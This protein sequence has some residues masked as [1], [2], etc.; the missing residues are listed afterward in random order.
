MCQMDTNGAD[1]LR[2]LNAVCRQLFH[3]SDPEEVEQAI[4][5]LRAINPAHVLLP[6][7]EAKARQLKME[8]GVPSS[9]S[10]RQRVSAR[11]AN[12]E[13]SSSRNSPYGTDLG[14]RRA[15]T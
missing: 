4:R 10:D 13:P 3:G 14:L 8:I 11:A 6:A 2:A 5:A 7:L 12:S 9:D 1:Y 15:G